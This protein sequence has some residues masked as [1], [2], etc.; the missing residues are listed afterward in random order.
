M[1]PGVTIDLNFHTLDGQ[2][3]AIGIESTGF[4]R[5]KIVN[6]IVKDFATGIKLDGAPS[7]SISEVF[8]VN[9]KQIGLHMIDSDQ[10]KLES[11]HA[12]RTTDGEGIVLDGGSGYSLKENVATENFTKGLSI[13]SDTSGGKFQKNSF[14]SN[15]GPGVFVD[16]GNTV[17]SKNLVGANRD[18]GG[19]RGLQRPR[20]WVQEQPSQRERG[21]ASERH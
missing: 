11:S 13:E 21:A 1:N 20:K 2:N 7:S 12:I 18:T 3:A 19:S 15:G 14:V 8:M 10:S 9:N 17:F 16:G 4:D 5:V 6:G